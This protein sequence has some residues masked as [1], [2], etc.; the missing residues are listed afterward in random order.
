MAR[1][2]V[3]V[4]RNV[5]EALEALRRVHKAA[6]GTPILVEDNGAI[7]Q[8]EVPEGVRI[9]GRN[10]FAK[11]SDFIVVIGGDGTL[12]HAAS[13]VRD[14]VVPIV[15]I[16]LGHVGF[17]TAVS[18]D[19]IERA[20]PLAL[21]GGLPH[22][23]RMRLD[24]RVTSMMGDVV[25]EKRVLN[26]VA[27]TPT[28]MARLAEYRIVQ[29][30]QLVTSLRGDGIIVSTPTGSTAY[31]MAAGGS[32]IWPGMN[33]IA[34]TPICPHSLTQRPLILDATGDLDIRLVGKSE[35]TAT[36]DGQSSCRFTTGDILTVTIAPVPTRLLSLP[37]G[38]FFQTLRS[39]LHWG[40]T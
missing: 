3:I 4:K 37:G 7:S 30:G 1:L 10:E 38:S 33:A 9:V 14:R 20:I 25:T 35:V 36:L 15:G 6:R 17:L 40:S 32:I 21:E 12:I 26:D 8:A 24:V 5:K 22:L 31:S 18:I 13:L 2:G 34:V 28:V 27:L 19:E 16:N 29:D 39:K 11:V 23:D